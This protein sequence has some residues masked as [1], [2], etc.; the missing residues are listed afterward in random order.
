M[1]L[2][3]SKRMFLTKCGHVLYLLA[4]TRFHAAA[5][6]RVRKSSLN[7]E[8]RL[9]CFS[10]IRSLACNIALATRSIPSQLGQPTA[11][12]PAHF[13]PPPFRN[14]K[15]TPVRIKLLS[16]LAPLCALMLA[17]STAA[18]Q[19]AR[20]VAT[21]HD[22]QIGADL[23]QHVPVREALPQPTE[24]QRLKLENLQLKATLLSQ[25]QALQQE[26]GALVQ[27]IIAEHPGYIWNPQTA[28]LQPAPKPAP[29]P[30]P[31]VK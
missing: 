7:R 24:V 11:A 14:L 6:S 28:S 29:Q 2:P 20:P 12:L 13:Y 17:A 10:Q 22:K 5:A 26:Y 21:G 23:A 19:T 25:Q 3:Q 1:N 18:S 9:L 8:E 27:A 4:C 31:A 30:K 16:V 15:G